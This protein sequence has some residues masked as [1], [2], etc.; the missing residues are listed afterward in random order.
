MTYLQLGWDHYYHGV[1]SQDHAFRVPADAV[2][3]RLNEHAQEVYGCEYH[4]LGE[5]IDEQRGE[6][7][8]RVVAMDVLR[9]ENDWD[10]VPETE[11]DVLGWTCIP[12][13]ERPFLEFDV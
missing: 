3:R 1:D 10:R 4:E 2:T 11:Y 7:A 6:L 5:Q 9:L 12:L 13:E 8:T